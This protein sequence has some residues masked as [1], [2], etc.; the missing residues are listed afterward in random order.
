[1]KILVLSVGKPRNPL[2]KNEVEDYQ[3]RVSTRI[4]CGWEH[5]R[6]SSGK[7]P[8]HVIASEE[9]MALLKKVGER[10]YFVL[11]DES[12]KTMTSVGFSEWLF[13]TVSETPGKTILAVGGAFGVSREVKERANEILSLSS[14]TLTHEMSLLLLFE[15]IYRAVTIEKG[16]NYHHGSIDPLK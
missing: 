1:L 7:K 9:G 10:D 2:L 11:L 3:Q 16:G 4:P 5:V 15:Q 14:M 13:R 8:R 6:E 12:G